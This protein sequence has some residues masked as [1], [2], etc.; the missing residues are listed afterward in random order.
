MHISTTIFF[1]CVVLLLNCSKKT[2]GKENKSPLVVLTAQLLK[3]NPFLFEFRAE[4]SDQEFDPL[5]FTWNFGQGTI[6]EGKQVEQFSYPEN[7]SFTISVKVT[8]GKST[9]VEKSVTI[10]TR[11]LEVRADV[12]KKYQVME[13]FGGFGA[14]DV[15]WTDGPFSSPDFINDVV[16]DLGLT[17]I[18][19]ELPTSFE[20]VNDNNDPLI[21][22]LTKYN[23]DSRIEG[24]HQP[25]GKRLQYWRDLKAAG[26]NK[27]IAS[28]WSPAPWM[29]HNNQ[30]GNGTSN[31]NSAPPYTN[32]P[33][34]TTN[35][36]KTDLYEEF[37]ES[38]VA[39]IRVIKQQT[40]IDLYALSIQNEPRFSQFYQ[41]CVYNGTALR[42]LLK[43]V[44]K[45]FRNE[46]IATRL[47]LPEDIGWLGG[48]EAMI[49]PSLDD[50]E[51]RQ[52]VDIVAVHGYDLDGVTAASPN[53]QTW[54]TMYSWGAAYGKPLWMTETS[55]FANNHEGAIALAKAMFTAIRFGNISAWVFWTLSTSTL[56]EYSLM[57]SAGVKSKRYYVSKNF[58]KYIRPGAQRFEVIAPETSRIYPLG[59]SNSSDQSETL[60]FIND[61]KD[62][63]K[64]IRLTGVT[65]QFSVFVTSPTRNCE[66]QGTISSLDVLVLPASSVVTLYKKN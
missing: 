47:F 36:L 59:F 32:S 53:A 6:R 57:S 54:Q 17:I 63:D 44:G 48:V 31:T 22:D 62:R 24:H 25:L 37:A 5:S 41:S 56:D 49:K 40:G 3:A 33:N 14:K 52:Y 42:D 43:V 50:P 66:Q 4:A 45:R 65:G 38:C 28:V 21:T 8:D 55:G 58:Y 18:R 27:F 34:N 29:K 51:A 15:Y 60:V 20:I 16:N 9:P 12:S 2:S 23:L 64:A 26:V 11:V 1:V 39:Y 19:D 46:G 13:G 7:G 35:Q 10:D 30:L 61:N